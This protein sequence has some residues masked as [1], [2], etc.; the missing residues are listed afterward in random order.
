MFILTITKE[1]KIIQ[2]RQ[3]YSALSCVEFFAIAHNYYQSRNEVV[4]VKMLRADET[5]IIS[6]MSTEEL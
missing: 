6:K 1:E 4:E 5:L 2:R 3:Y